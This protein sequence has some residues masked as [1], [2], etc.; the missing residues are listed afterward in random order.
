[1]SPHLVAWAHT[2]C[3]CQPDTDPGFFQACL[4]HFYAEK[5]R[6]ACEMAVRQPVDL[7]TKE[8]LTAIL[9]RVGRF[10]A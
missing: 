1:M 10:N 7:A 5:L 4:L 6:L 9:E 3:G 8:Y 2:G